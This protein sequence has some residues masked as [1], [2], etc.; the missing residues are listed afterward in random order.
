MSWIEIGAIV[1]SNRNWQFSEPF[2]GNLIKIENKVTARST[3][4]APIF[5]GLISLA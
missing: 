1:S 4:V 2:A 5:R 3:G